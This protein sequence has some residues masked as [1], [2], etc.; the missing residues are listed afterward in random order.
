VRVNG[1]INNFTKFA[2]IDKII[3]ADL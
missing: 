2:V 1:V 3:L